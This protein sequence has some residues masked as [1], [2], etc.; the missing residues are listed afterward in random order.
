MLETKLSGETS[1]KPESEAQRGTAG[2]S[3]TGWGRSMQT[4]G[5]HSYEEGMNLV[6][7]Q[8]YGTTNITVLVLR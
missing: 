7:D 6:R 3:R 8:Y 2:L 5:G 1:I 4:R